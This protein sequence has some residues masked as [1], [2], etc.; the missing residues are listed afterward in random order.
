MHGTNMKLSGNVRASLFL[1][2]LQS[3]LEQGP[4]VNGFLSRR[5]DASSCGQSKRG[6]LACHW[7]H[8]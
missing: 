6:D 3:E 4:A 1:G 7:T 5:D 2:I 8:G